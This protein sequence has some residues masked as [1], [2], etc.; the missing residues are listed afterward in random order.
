[1]DVFGGS[2][3]GKKNKSIGNLQVGLQMLQNEV[4]VHNILFRTHRADITKCSDTITD[5]RTAVQKI[6]SYIQ[7]M[8]A[9]IKFDSPILVYDQYRLQTEITISV[10]DR[11][12]D[13]VDKIQ[14]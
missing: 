7:L 11:S 10:E 13:L 14:E 12:D 2:L 5:I 1:M 4:D 3:E 6:E 8:A 9:N